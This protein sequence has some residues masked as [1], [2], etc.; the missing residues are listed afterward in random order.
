MSANRRDGSGGIRRLV[1]VAGIGRSGT[2]LLAGILAQLGYR[3]PQPEVEADDSNPRGFSEPRWVV[4]FHTRLMRARRVT[5][6]DSRPEAW[7]LMGEAAQDAEVVEELTSWLAV[8]FVGAQ[9]LVVKDPRIGWFLPLWRRCADDLGSETSFVTMLRYPPEVV[10]SAREWYG[11]WQSDPSRAAA[12]LN[13]TLHTEHATRGERRAFVRY[14]SL[15]E[16]WP[17]EISRVGE[18]IGAPELA[19][20]DRGRFPDVDTLVDPSLRRADAGWAEVPV[21]ASVQALAEQVWGLVS[22]LGDSGGDDEQTRASLDEARSAFVRLHREAEAIAQS[23]ITA[24]KPRRRPRRAPTA[25]RS[26]A[27]GAS[28]ARSRLRRRLARALPPKYR[29]RLRTLASKGLVT[30]G[31]IAALP[32][33]AAFLV[34]PRYRERVPLPVV[35]AGLR[36]VRA[37]RR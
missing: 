6:F 13:V 14:E 23:A 10:R 19:R 8:H 11:A 2:S 30:G 4:D 3:V 37:L 17:R 32:M 9:D 24:V 16:D 36:I 25:P 29:D 26:R 12:W 27:G 1:L 22:R 15:L 35:R 5:V 28:R 21:P 7:R 20:P 34:P 33:R 18:L 31:G